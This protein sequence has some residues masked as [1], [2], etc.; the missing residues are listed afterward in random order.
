MRVESSATAITWLPFEA[1]DRMPSVPLELAV[2]AYDEPPPVILPE[3]EELRRRDTFREANELRA[4]IDVRD[5]AIVDYGYEGRSMIGDAGLD[6][7]FRQV[8]FAAVEFPVIRPDPEVGEGWIRF[9]QTAGGRIGLPAPRPVSGQPFFHVGAISAWT[10]VE[11]VLH[12]GGTTESR[13]VAASPFPQHSLYDAGRRLVSSTKM[14]DFEPWY[15]E[16]FGKTPWG[17][18]GTPAFSA[19]VASELERTLATAILE[20]GLRFTRRRIPAG[21]ALVRQGDPGGELFI[22]LDG[23]LDVDIDGETIAQVGSGAILGERA[24]LRDGRRTA[25]LRAARAVRVAV[26]AADAIGRPELERL[27]AGRP[28]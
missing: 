7:G 6:L 20:D 14:L 27:S 5:E 10:T 23:V 24:I 21:A 12:A 3:L 2:A 1:L 17:H 15:A 11:L 25:T 26:V 22:L 28:G 18:E 4:W 16:V 19:A 9:R 13:L 8:A